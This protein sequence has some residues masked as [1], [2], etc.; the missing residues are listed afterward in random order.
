MLKS[1]FD[2]LF[3]NLPTFGLS[4]ATALSVAQ[5]FAAFPAIARHVISRSA[6]QRP[7]QEN[8][9]LL[10]LIPQLGSDLRFARRP[11]RAVPASP[12]ARFFVALLCEREASDISSLHPPIHL[13]Q[14]CL[15]GFPRLRPCSPSSV[16]RG[17]G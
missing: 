17:L 13:F 8:P 3:T 5:L 12:H 4:P 10:S 7:S 2:L 16:D 9:A 15:V 11:R 1:H 6:C 14:P